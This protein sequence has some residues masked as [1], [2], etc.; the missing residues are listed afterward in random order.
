MRKSRG[1]SSA[2]WERIA[3]AVKERDGWR[4]RECGG[5]GALEAHHV[6]PVH[7]GG[8][9]DLANLVA[10]CRT[11]HIRKHTAPLKGGWDAIRE[12]IV[13]RVI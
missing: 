8:S 5:A 11:C 2:E 9:D 12:G 10:L 3:H 13:R 1:I 4:C 6:I 7:A